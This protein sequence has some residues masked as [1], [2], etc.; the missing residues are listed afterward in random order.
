M[1]QETK[2]YDTLGIKPEA[3]QDEIKKGYRKAA[4]KY[5]PD[6][7]KDDP[8]A[9]E[10]FK[11]CSQAYEILSDPE[12]RKVYDQYGLDFLTRGAPPPPE[13][14]GANPFAGAGGGM[15]GGFSGFDFGG[16]PGGGGGGGGARTFHFS[17]GGGGGPGGFNFTNPEEIFANFMRAGGGGGGGMGGMGGMPDED[18]D[19]FSSFGGGAGGRPRQSASAFRGGAKRPQTP[20]VLS[21][22]RP[23]PLTL[24]D[25]FHGVTKRMK[26]KAKRFD[27]D[28]KQITKDQIL[29]VPIKAGLKKGSKIKFKE[30]GDQVEGG[31]QDLHFIV[32]EK[33]HPLFK[34]EDNDLIHTVTLDLKEALTGW[35]RTV[36]TIDGKQINLDKAGPT[37]PGSEDRYPGLGMP[38][39][40]K[41]GSRGDFI[42]KYKVNFPS[43]L[44]AEQKQKL[45]EIL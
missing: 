25:L 31:R 11:E 42:I 12:K 36:T 37:Q 21:V 22:E 17:T 9:A 5:H 10:K 23:L 7:N 8:Q 13:E 3:S 41:A 43:S 18:Y 1:V 20:E 26:I 15:P 27:A 19:M 6:K 2:L 24:E 4:L 40:K 39:S 35:K 29:E 34:R 14:G 32:E 38:L 30:V 16:M 33:P 44:T 28:G 45:R